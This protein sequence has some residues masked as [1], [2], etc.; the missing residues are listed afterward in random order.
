MV[1]IC[2]S[3]IAS[4][5]SSQAMAYLGNSVQIDFT[6]SNSTSTSTTPDTTTLSVNANPTSVTSVSSISL[7]STVSDVSNSAS[8]P[9]GSISWSDGGT[10]GTFSASSCTLSSGSCGVSYTPSANS[11]SSVTITASY[12]GD[13]SHQSSSGSSNLSILLIHA[14]SVTI[15]SSSTSTTSGSVTLTATIADTTD[16]QAVPTGSVSWSDGNAG[17]TFSSS[18]C[19]LSSGACQLTYT[20]SPASSSS[21]VTI[22]ASYG[23]DTTHQTSSGS[24]NISVS[25]IDTT[26]VTV[27]PSSTA[28][29][30]GNVTLTATISNLSN[31]QS[32]PTGT[33]S[34][35][36]GGAGGTFSTSSCTLSS[37]AC[38]T[39]YTPST[40]SPSSITITASYG[41]D[42]THKTSSGTS[43]LSVNLLNSSI[44]SVSHNPTTVSS[45]GSVNFTA[46]VTSSSSSQTVPSGLVSWS[47]GN[48]GGT[49]N[50]QSCTLSSGSC[51]VSY[52]PSLNPPNVTT[53]TAS[54]AG[55]NSYQPSTGS[56]QLSANVI[57]STVTTITPN[58]AQVTGGT[59]VTFTATI[60]DSANPST[61]I[62]GLVKW[63]DNGAGGSFSPDVCIVSNNH[64]SLDYTPPANL[65]GQITITASYVGD[66][67]HSGSSGSSLVTP[68]PQSTPTAPSQTSPQ[69]TPN[70]ITQSTPPPVSQPSTPMPSPIVP[71]SPPVTAPTQTSPSSSSHASSSS[72]TT[73]TPTMPT[74]STT[75][76]PPTSQPSTPQPSQTQVKSSQPTS[77]PISSAKPLQTNNLQQQAVQE[78]D[79]AI[80]NVVS[81]L[82]SL[83]SKL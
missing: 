28:I 18:S 62:I 68:A 44:V 27:S 11:P 43:S 8:T 77:Q 76:S 72:T 31:A 74:P 38:Q 9:T 19:I 56:N 45:G 3:L 66:S 6:Q 60:S 67:T 30:S 73:P 63:S 50:T 57:D 64:C 5:S 49:F 36:D 55:D 29:V 46:T 40:N 21:S 42:T 20:P 22:T 82:E 2:I 25:L 78:I 70:S 52:T 59:L 39:A 15:S 75:S 7:T 47:D 16:S 35:S 48:A 23:G 12:G 65:S 41:G 69:S 17:G 24:S 34:W 79:N 13:T 61:V 1:G 54:Y 81:I 26:A 14:T 32:V 58:P 33:I 71:Q 80:K 10:G 4:S 53:I 51:T 37:N 83:F